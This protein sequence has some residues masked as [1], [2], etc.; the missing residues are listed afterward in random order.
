MKHISASKKRTVFVGFSIGTLVSVV[1]SIVLSLLL[2]SLIQNKNVVT[3]LTPVIFVTRLISILVGGV[4]GSI[5]TNEKCVIV[6]S[7]IL[8]AYLII[9]I[10]IGI[11]FC[12]GQFQK[13]GFSILSVLIGGI[14]AGLICLK[15]QNKKPHSYKSVR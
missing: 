12:E 7:F 15:M 3:S 14:I 10:S 4:I 9:L 2:T 1:C 8:S 11:L 13:M 6:I 5:I